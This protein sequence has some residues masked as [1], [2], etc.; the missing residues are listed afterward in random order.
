M[1]SFKNFM[2]EGIK[3]LKNWKDRNRRG[4]ARL[5]L[6]IT[7]GNSSNKYNDDFGFTQAEMNYMDK[8]CSKV[9]D[10]HISSFDGG[11]SAPASME[12]VGKKASLEKFSKDREIQKICK[13]YKCKVDIYDN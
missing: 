3:D 7:K 2:A 10:I 13:K 12:F 11:D 8:L 4:E 6:E 1:K 5:Y 9:R